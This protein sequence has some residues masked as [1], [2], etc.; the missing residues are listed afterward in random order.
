MAQHTLFVYLALHQYVA[1]TV[2]SHPGHP[3][4]LLLPSYSSVDPEGYSFIRHPPRPF[5]LDTYARQLGPPFPSFPQLFLRSSA[6]FP[7]PLRNPPPFHSIHVVWLDMWRSDINVD[8]SHLHPIHS[9]LSVPSGFI[10]SNGLDAVT[11]LTFR[12]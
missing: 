9:L 10:L 2:H 3:P 7:V 12:F 1:M 4:V 5:S 8:F 6:I 11:Y